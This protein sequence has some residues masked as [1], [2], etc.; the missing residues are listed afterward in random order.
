MKKIISIFLT[1]LMLMAGGTACLSAVPDD[2]A[3]SCLLMTLD[4]EIIYS[5]RFTV[6]IAPSVLDF[7]VPEA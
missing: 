2:S 3:K 6:K 5:D 4:G 1:A 7:A